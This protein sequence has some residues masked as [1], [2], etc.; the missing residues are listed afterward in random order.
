MLH[1]S[2]SSCVDVLKS[3][4]VPALE[5]LYQRKKASKAGLGSSRL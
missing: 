2:Y 4:P 5:R 3:E 1:C